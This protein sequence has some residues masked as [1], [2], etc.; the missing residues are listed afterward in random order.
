MVKTVLASS[1]FHISF[2]TSSE[3]NIGLLNFYFILFLRIKFKRI[4]FLLEPNFATGLCYNI[5]TITRL[6]NMAFGGA[7]IEIGAKL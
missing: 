1:R 4:N 3:F 2:Q 6:C 7:S 5:S